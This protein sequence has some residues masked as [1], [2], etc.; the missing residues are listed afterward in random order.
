MLILREQISAIHSIRG[1]YDFKG[2]V[3][4]SEDAT[5][6]VLYSED[7]KLNPPVYSRVIMVHPIDHIDETLDYVDENIQ[8]IGLASSRS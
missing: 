7:K 6:T 5:W 2:E 4:A 3:W 8:T 1:L